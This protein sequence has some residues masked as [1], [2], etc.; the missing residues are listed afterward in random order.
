MEKQRQFG[1]FFTQ[2]N[3]FYHKAFLRWASRASL[4]ER[5]VLEPFAGANHI[6][7]HLKD[8]ELCKQY[9][10]YDIDPAHAAV[11][12]RDTLA[13]FP[14]GFHVCITNPPW[15]AKNS[16]TRRGLPYADEGYD[17]LYKLALDRCLSNCDYVAALVPESF[18]RADL[19]QGRMSD[20]V[21]LPSKLFRDTSHPVGLALFLP[22]GCSDVCIWSGSRPVG[23]LSALEAARPKSRKNGTSVIFNDPAGNVGLIAL[24]NTKGASIRF[25]SVEELAGY[26]VKHSCRVI[27]KLSVAGRVNIKSWNSYIDAFRK[28]TEDVLLTCY[29]GVRLD[30]K[31]RR[32][33]DWQ[34]ARGIIQ[35]DGSSDISSGL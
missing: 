10:S 3:P 31:Y 7:S 19:F 33:M 15:L 16:A 4:P 27:T 35:H 29:R 25:C 5:K 24:D 9:S 34:L 1:Q 6:I 14:T 13:D 2:I 18:I 26:R 11:Q 23:T 20:F 12:F 17:D 21:S 32:R 28:K 8:M 22:T 30:G